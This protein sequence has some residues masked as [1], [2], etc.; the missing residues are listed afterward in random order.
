M[1]HPSTIQQGLKEFDK[2]LA[3][4]PLSWTFATPPNVVAG[5]LSR[6]E[7]LRSKL[8]SLFLTLANER[9]ESL[10]KEMRDELYIADLSQIENQ[11]KVVK[12][13][14]Y[15]SAKLEEIAYLEK[16]IKQLNEIR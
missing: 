8:L 4:L 12:D 7:Q 9:I 10:K 2:L 5:G 1:T 6:K 16:I 11:I 15:N 13:R 14:S 3:K